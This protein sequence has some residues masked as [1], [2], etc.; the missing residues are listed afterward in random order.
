V[1]TEHWDEA[2][3]DFQQFYGL[4]LEFEFETAGVR[5]LAA[6]VLHLP[7]ESRIAAADGDDGSGEGQ[8]PAE[9]QVIALSELGGWIG[10]RGG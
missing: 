4:D 7:A 6:L 9:P 3:A 2:E 5:R 10:K 8:K 1:L